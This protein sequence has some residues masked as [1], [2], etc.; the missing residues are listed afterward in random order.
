MAFVAT[1]GT[2][3]SRLRPAIAIGG[4]VKMQFMTWSAASG[5]TSGTVTA[6]ALAEVTGILIDGVQQTAAATFS[7]NVVTLAFKDPTTVLATKGDLV[8]FGV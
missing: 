3:S 7:G 1:D 5:D 4:S 2:D 8:V 6:D